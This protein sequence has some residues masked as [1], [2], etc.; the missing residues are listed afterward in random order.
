M[1]DIGPTNS[2]PLSPIDE[3][4]SANVDDQYIVCEDVFEDSEEAREI[5]HTAPKRGKQPT[6]REIE[7][8]NRTHIPFRSWCKFCVSA[9]APNLPHRARNPDQSAIKNEIAADYCFLRDVSGGPSQPVLVGRDRKTG[10]FF[11]HAVPYKGAGV[12][13]VAQQ[14]ARDISKCGYHGRVVLRSDQEPASQDLMGEVARLRGDLPTVLE[15][16][17][18]GDS[19]SNGFVERAVRSVEEMIR[20]HKIA[21]EAKVGEKLSISHSAIGWM[22]EHCADILNKC[23][24]GR[25][26]RTPYER[27]KGKKYG[28]TFMEFGSPVM[29]RVTDKPQGGLMQERWV[30]GI[31]LG[32]RFNTLEHLVSRRS[33]GVVVRTRAVREIPPQVQKSD[34]DSIVGQPHAP[35]GVQRKEKFEIPRTC[36]APPTEPAMPTSGPDPFRPVPRAVY[37]TKAMLEKHGYAA[38]C[39]KCRAIQRCQ[40]QTTIGH[41]TDC[42]K[43]MEELLGN[44]MEY[45]HRLEQANERINHYL[46]KELEIADK[47]RKLI[48]LK[49][50]YR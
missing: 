28:G 38:N 8:H 11:A 1:R 10:M 22:I 4:P 36:V 50:G 39:G 18:V 17:P 46:A 15:A 47:K 42:R 20:T 19:Q 2:G 48:P 30:E 43:R 49:D 16:S 45:Q 13:W 9:R 26:G 34:L 3:A 31:W 27:L 37:I 25:D 14:M 24:V 40:S 44:D 41:T 7:E 32:S 35:Q 6:G 23:Q 21:L 29:L 33:D 5:P 12:E